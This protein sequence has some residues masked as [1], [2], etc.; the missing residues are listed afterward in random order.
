MEKYLFKKVELW[1]VALILL[2]AL[3]LC[4]IWG[5]N[6]V[7]NQAW[8]WTMIKETRVFVA[9]DQDEDTTLAAKVKSLF[10]GTERFEV[11]QAEVRELTANTK[12]ASVTTEF[13]R[14]VKHES[15]EIHTSADQGLYLFYGIMDLGKRPQPT[16]VLMNTR[17]EILRSW[18]FPFADQNNNINR[19]QYSPNGVVVSTSS[20]LFRA[21]SWCGEPLWQAEGKGYHHEADY[22]E[23]RF[24]LWHKDKVV[25]VDEFSGAVEEII[26]MKTIVLANPEIPLMRSTLDFFR[27]DREN[28]DL[29]FD[30]KQSRSVN[31][32]KKKLIFLGNNFHQNKAAVN[33]GLSDQFP[34]GSI[35]ISLR[36][37]D[38]VAVINP[39]TGKILW[40][41]TFNRQHDPDWAQ[42]GL[43]IY[44]N[45]SHFG[46]TRIEYAGFDG[47]HEILVGEQ[48]MRWFRKI[49]GN[50]SLYLDGSIIFQGRRGEIHHMDADKQMITSFISRLAMR[51]G[52]FLTDQE[53]AKFEASCK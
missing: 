18:E 3:P 5:M 35:A 21:Q 44:N 36:Q 20:T 2:V 13:D 34:K 33:Y 49:T 50:S 47:S 51:N 12:E 23:G 29:I 30:N 15:F 32:D 6:I 11:K 53:V 1:L 28:A 8:P 39:Q 14:V 19:F 17:G 41:R 40:H 37:V 52:Y 48:Q 38:L 25:S 31:T 9:G 45:R 27:Y 10:G 4:V 16:A 43:V 22:G 46:N 24:T 42:D 7:E 26:D